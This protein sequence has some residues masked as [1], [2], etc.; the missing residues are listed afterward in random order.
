MFFG[1]W[2]YVVLNETIAW[3]YVWTACFPTGRME[4]VVIRMVPEWSC[5]YS[6]C[7]AV[8]FPCVVRDMCVCCCVWLMCCPGYG[9]CLRLCMVRV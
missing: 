5:V 4:C 6:V 7:G 1:G 9:L 8:Y 3:S 2:S